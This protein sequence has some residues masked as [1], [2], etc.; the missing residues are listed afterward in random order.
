MS[1]EGTKY[2]ALPAATSVNGLN[3]LGV[4]QFGISRKVTLHQ[5]W[6]GDLNGLQQGAIP[7]AGAGGVPT[8]DATHLFWDNINKRLGVGTP[9]PQTKLH[10][11]SWT[12]NDSVLR[13]SAPGSTDNFIKF[14]SPDIGGQTSGEAY[15]RWQR[16]GGNGRRF[17][18]HT[19]NGSGTPIDAVMVDYN[20]NV[21]IGTMG[22]GY[23]VQITSITD[24]AVQPAL[25]LVNN[26]QDGSGDEVS[27]IGFLAG[28]NPDA[29][30][31]TAIAQAR[32]YN[33]YGRGALVF[34][35]RNAADGSSVTMSDEV[36]RITPSGNVG[37]GITGPS[38]QLQLSQDSAAKPST[39]TWTV[40]SDRRLKANIQDADLQRC[41]EIV[42]SIPL[43]YYRWRDE[44]YSAEQVQDRGKLGWIAD[45]VQAVFPKAVNRAEFVCPPVEDGTEEYDEPVMEEEQVEQTSIEII[46][47]VPTQVTKTVTQRKPVVDYVPVVDAEGITVTQADGTPLLYPVPRTRKATRP[48]MRRETIPDCLSLNADQL[49]AAMYGAIQFL[50]QKVERLEARLMERT[51]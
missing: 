15:L 48:K 35:Q 47:G 45:E 7:F 14:A 22:P 1:V 29:G 3:E 32:E 17:S 31:K 43:R 41:Y 50:Q 2:S 4:N 13:L 24:P 23:K 6:S 28:N 8:Q 39:N 10:I 11:N 9:V 40:S 21:G 44:V 46:N 33:S 30:V 20:G 19:V 5:I 16:D 34:L 51:V 12:V 49:F 36:M 27:G 18:I 25:I 26:Y 37:I 42:K 38:Y